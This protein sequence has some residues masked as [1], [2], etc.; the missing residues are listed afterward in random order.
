VQVILFMH[1]AG[2][3]SFIMAALAYGFA[4]LFI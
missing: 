2:M 1:G 4:T 3:I